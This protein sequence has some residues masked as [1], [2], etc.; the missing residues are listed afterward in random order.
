MPL[1]RPES[2]PL[3]TALIA[4]V[5]GLLGGVGGRKIGLLQMRSELADLEDLVQ[6]QGRRISRR[7]GEHGAE[8]KRSRRDAEEEIN[9]ELTEAVA[10]GLGRQQ[11][12]PATLDEVNAAARAA[13][14]SP[15]GT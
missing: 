5:A 12:A 15:S 1:R 13:F 3:L 6:Q 4:L 10:R 9:Q 8:R 14:P 11:R 7:E 2:S